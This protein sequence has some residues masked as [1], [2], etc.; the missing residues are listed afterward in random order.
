MFIIGMNFNEVIKFLPRE[1]IIAELGVKRG[2][3]ARRLFQA[4]SPKKLFLVD[5]WGMDEDVGY[6]G[7]ISDEDRRAIITLT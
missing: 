6:A 3:N 4:L 7:R 2:S 1:S 5:P